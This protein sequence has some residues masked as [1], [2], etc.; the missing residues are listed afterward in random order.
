VLPAYLLALKQQGVS[1]PALARAAA[2]PIGAAV[3]TGA[4][5]WAST[6]AIDVAWQA[7]VLGG[8]IGILIYLALLRRWLRS[9]LSG[10]WPTRWQRSAPQQRRTTRS[11]AASQRSRPDHVR[12]DLLWRYKRQGAHRLVRGRSSPAHAAERASALVD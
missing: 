7:L 6:H 12:S 1:L 10:S 4:G 9:R 8:V 2:P 5:V 3:V 11:P